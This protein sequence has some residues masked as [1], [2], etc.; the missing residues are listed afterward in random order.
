MFSF[1][2]CLCIISR[3]FLI[4]F[5]FGL[6]P[7]FHVKTVIFAPLLLL[8][9]VGLVLHVKEVVVLNAV[10]QDLNRDVRTKGLILFVFVG[11]YILLNVVLEGVYYFFVHSFIG[12]I[13]VEA[14]DVINIG[15]QT[16]NWQVL[17][18]GRGDLM[19]MLAMFIDEQVSVVGEVAIEFT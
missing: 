6:P 4:F 18:S 13:S 15:N 7:H 19:E 12:L 16:L 8:L 2:L 10:P 9:F 11:L 17:Q 3:A 14:E 5:Y 1:A